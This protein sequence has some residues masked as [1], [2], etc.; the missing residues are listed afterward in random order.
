MAKGMDRR[1]EE[2][3]PPAVPK[4]A[5]ETGSRGGRAENRL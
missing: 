1:K 5:K 4:G 2:K 3:K